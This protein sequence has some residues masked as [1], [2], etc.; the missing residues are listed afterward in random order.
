MTSKENESRKFSRKESKE[1]SKMAS[2]SGKQK[3]ILTENSNISHKKMYFSY[4]GVILMVLMML[5][6][7]YMMFPSR[8]V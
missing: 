5:V 2:E 8:K 4:Q 1:T 7:G 6:A 3:S